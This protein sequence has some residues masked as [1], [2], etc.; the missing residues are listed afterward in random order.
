MLDLYAAKAG[1][2]PLE[3]RRKNDRHPLRAL[4]W[5]IG[6]ENFGWSTWR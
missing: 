4:Q 5:L 6:A 3:V 1:L 2:D